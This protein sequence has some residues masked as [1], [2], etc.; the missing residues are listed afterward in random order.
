MCVTAGRAAVPGRGGRHTVVPVTAAQ[1][2]LE[3]PP[4][5]P[6]PAV[7]RSSSGAIG[8]VLAGVL[9]AHSGSAV[10]ASLFPRAGVWA[11][12]FMRLAIGAILLLA[13]CRPSPRGRSRSDWAL[14]GM[15]GLVLAGMN[16]IF[17]ASIQRIP[18]GIAVTLEVLGPL[19]LSV[20]AARRASAWL[21]AGLA[22]AGVA[23]L[24]R[25]GFDRL[26]PA[27]VVMALVAGALWAA[28]IVLSARTGKRFPRR[29]DGLALA[30]TVAAVLVLP[31]G[32]AGS[33]PVVAAPELLLLGVVVAVLCSVLPYSLEMLALRRIRTETFAVLMSLGPA[34]AACA[35][36]V[37]LGQ[38]MHWTD[39]LA[40][41]L[42]VTASAGAVRAG[43]AGRG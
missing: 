2:A 41:V 13:I 38:S 9:S 29:A 16:T 23:L 40:I 18:L 33:G 43:S 42:V 5:A 15:F 25:G 20:L 31:L 1:P 21:W 3:I 8:L 14:I 7:R 27:G 28:Y 24:G 26:D 22:L 19:T 30:M 39:I 6:G 35:G 10:A 37:I 17:F 32:I 4:S 36:L 12:V 11:V 34:I